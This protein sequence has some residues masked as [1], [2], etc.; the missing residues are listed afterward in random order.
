MGLVLLL[1]A[2]TGG[3][4]LALKENRCCFALSVYFYT[5]LGNDKR[6]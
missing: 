2:A 3:E 1:T 4:C 6:Y 5:L